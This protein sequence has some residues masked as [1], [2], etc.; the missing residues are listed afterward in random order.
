M[1]AYGAWVFGTLAGF[2]FEADS[3][4]LHGLGLDFALAAM[5]L[6]VLVQQVRD[7]RAVAVALF[8]AVIALSAKALGVGWLA[9]SLSAL[10]APVLGIFLEV[11]C[12]PKK[13]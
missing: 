4:Q 9:I 10:I 6:A 2:A 11:R 5:V 12:N 8:A 13:S 1:A 7:M 3:S